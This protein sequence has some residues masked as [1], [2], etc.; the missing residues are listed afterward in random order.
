MWKRW[1]RKATLQPAN[2]FEVLGSAQYW[3]VVCPELK[4]YL[5]ILYSLMHVPSGADDEWATPRPGEDPELLWEEFW[6]ALDFI[7]LQL[8]R[9]VRSSFNASFEKLLP[10]RE[11]L[12]LP[13][14]AARS[15]MVGGDATLGRFGGV[16][17]KLAGS[18]CLRPRILPP[19]SRRSSPTLIRL[20]SLPLWSS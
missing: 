18:W 4:P 17:G 7:R 9:P 8:E 16:I 15:R 3:S 14:M 20:K 10:I 5:P 1:R 19:P 6:D 2:S 11:L 13:G 12:A